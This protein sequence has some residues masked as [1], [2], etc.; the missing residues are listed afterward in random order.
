MESKN[1]IIR[2][3]IIVISLLLNIPAM[4]SAQIWHPCDANHDGVVDVADITTTAKYILTGEYKPSDIQV[5]ITRDATDISY[6]NATLNVSVIIPE[7]TSVL[8]I[9]VIYSKNPNPTKE[10]GTLISKNVS[11]TNSTPTD[12]SF[13]LSGLDHNTTYYFRA[14]A[15]TVPAMEDYYGEIKMFTTTN[16][17]YTEGDAIDL[18]LPSGVKWAS[19]NIGAKTPEDY[20]GYYAWGETEAKTEYSWTNYF[21]TNDEG[22]T[23]GKYTESC[24]L[25]LDDDVA[26]AKWGG[27][28]RMPTVDEMWELIE[29]CEFIWTTSKGVKGYMVK[30][31]VNGNAIFLPAGGYR[32]KENITL[33]GSDGYYWTSTLHPRNKQDAYLYSFAS[34]TS[35]SYAYRYWGCCVRP[36]CKPKTR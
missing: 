14:M 25:A 35:V 28:W 36:V 30:S 5:A 22:T 9:G 23:F 31:R 6:T 15:H 26:H 33:V 21:D 7:G 29:N 12:Y 19:V 10:N 20:G 18:G 4:V 34:S 8:T 17:E 11:I 3:K 16:V 1:T 13:P 24:N 2:L 27:D 32:K